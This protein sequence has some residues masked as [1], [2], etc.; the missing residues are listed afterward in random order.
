MTAF[1]QCG[2]GSCDLALSIGRRIGRGAPQPLQFLVE[3]RRC[4]RAP[5]HVE[6]GDKFTNFGL[7]YRESGRGESS[8][9]RLPDDEQFLVRGSAQPI[10]DDRD[11]IRCTRGCFSE[12]AVDKQRCQIGGGGHV[13]AGHPGLAV[14]AKT[15][16]H[17]ALRHREEAPV[18]A[19][20]CA[21]VERDTERAGG[22]V[23]LEGHPLDIVECGTLFGSG[24]GTTEYGEVPGDAAALG[25]VVGRGTG[26][27]IGHDQEAGVDVLGSEL[28]GRQ[29]E[30]HHVARA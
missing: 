11:A 6:A 17:G 2:C 10:E 22:V 1:A 3:P 21:A 23:G 5:G 15:Q 4:Q 20:Q 9:H 30:V 12:D 16:S 27:V 13:V 25:D 8:R 29:P 14:D 28:F 24:T 7:H 19:G 26:D 18:G